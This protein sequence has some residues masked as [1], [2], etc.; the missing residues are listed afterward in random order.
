MSISSTYLPL[1]LHGEEYFAKYIYLSLASSLF[2]MW[3]FGFYV[4]TSGW[5]MTD[6][7]WHRI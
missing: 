4:V 6:Y 1:F 3:I 7:Y 5:G 2:G